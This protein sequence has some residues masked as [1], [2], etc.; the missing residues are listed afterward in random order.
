MKLEDVAKALNEQ[1][2][3]L[4]VGE[5]K[6]FTVSPPLNFAQQAEVQWRLILSQSRLQIV[7]C[8][9]FVTVIRV[10]VDA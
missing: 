10:R 6:W 7:V 2:Q 9:E 1:C 3:G 8:E 4:P 5:V